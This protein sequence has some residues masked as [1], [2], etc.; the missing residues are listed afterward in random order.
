MGRGVLGKGR[1][2]Y[3]GQLARL[4]FGREKSFAS[5]SLRLS[6]VIAAASIVAAGTRGEAQQAQEIA[7]LAP[8]TEVVWLDQGW[9]EEQRRA[10]HHQSQGTVTVPIPTSWFLALQQPY[11]PASAGLFSDPAY[12]ERFGFIPSPRHAKDNPD[13][14]PVGFARTTGFNPRDGR[15]FDRLG[16][17]CAA[18]HTAQIDHAGT[19][20]LVDGGPALINLTAFGE[21]LALALV[22]TTSA[23]RFKRFADRVLGPGHS[24]GERLRLRA[25]VDRTI[26]DQVFKAITGYRSGGVTEGFGRLDALNRIGNTVFGA[27]MGLNQNLVPTTAPVAY[28]HIWDTHWFDWVQ[29]NGSIEQPMVRNAGEALG[30]SALVNFKDHPTPRFTSTVPIDKLYHP[31]ESSL[32]GSDP[33][34]QEKGFL[35]LRSPAWPEHIFGRIDRALAAQGAALYQD[36]CSSC[37]LP[38]PNTREFWTGDHWTQPNSAGER[39]LRLKNVAISYVGTDPAQATD[40]AN[41]TVVVPRALELERPVGGSGD[42]LRYK[43]GDALGQVVEKVANR[44]YDDQTPSTSKADRD[45]MNGHRKNGIRD[46]LNY[47]A[48]PLNGI[49]ATAPYLHNGSIRTL[50][51]LLSPYEERPWSFRLGSREFD[52]INIGFAN[53][54]PFLLVSRDRRGDP[55]KGN[56]NTGHLFESPADPAKKRD[57]TIG[58]ALSPQERRAL[59]EFLKTL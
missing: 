51:D 45:R 18:C 53:A 32:R 41:R 6:G 17:T 3:P 7:A 26:R 42:L 52:P 27:G 29:Y 55:V 36:R 20:V 13:A 31:I 8:P 24:A 35:G 14:L 30:V 50:W 38:A 33:P 59:I 28:P 1:F 15:P 10:Y 5:I 2:N 34:S 37:H 57:G 58:E 4:A 43:Y 23:P 48:R 22:Y 47:K 12:L 9:T 21:K 11:I 46:D 16:F 39:Y 19:S 49:W 25:E 40:M 54:G 56:R 44:W